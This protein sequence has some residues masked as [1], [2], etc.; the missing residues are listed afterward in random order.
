MSSLIERIEAASEG[1]RS[2]DWEIHL[3]DGL[4]GKGMFGSHPSYSTS[5]D[6]AMT[7]VPVGFE[8]SMYGAVG[9][10]SPQ[11]QLETQQMRDN[12]DY[13][14]S[15]KG[16]SIALALCAAAL[17]ARSDCLARYGE[18]IFGDGK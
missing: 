10:I 11:A 1:S 18:D 12:H 9:S 3:H 6:A 17:K 7:L 2:L 15:G 16:A 14:I 4:D 5:I 8:V 13:P